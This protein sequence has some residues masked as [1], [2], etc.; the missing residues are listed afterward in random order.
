MGYGTANSQA[1][2]M[3]NKT[4][5]KAKDFSKQQWQLAAKMYADNHETEQARWKRLG[6]ERMQRM[7]NK[8]KRRRVPKPAVAVVERSDSEV[9]GNEDG[10]ASVVGNECASDSEV[11]RHVA[12]TVPRFTRGGRKVAGAGFYALDK[13]VDK[14]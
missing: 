9:E 7:E 6:A 11:A 5:K 4:H 2:F 14:Q 8:R 3:M 13:Y 1:A 12:Q 10:Q